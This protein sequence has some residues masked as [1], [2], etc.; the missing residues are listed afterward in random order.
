MLQQSRR[1]RANPGS[2]NVLPE[3][4]KT[5]LRTRPWHDFCVAE[6]SENEPGIMDAPL[7]LF[8]PD[9]GIVT[10]IGDDHW[11][12][13][14]SREAIAREVG[15]LVFTLPASGTAV[16]NADDPLVAPLAAGC[17]ARVIS[18]GI[19]P[20]ADLRAE[21][22]SSN[23]P[24]KLQL[25]LVYNNERAAV[26]SQ[27]CGIHWVS[28]VLGAVAAGLALGLSLKECAAG[29]SGAA[30][31]AGRMEA[32]ALPGGPTFI[33]DD[34]KA[35]FWTVDS[36]LAFMAAAQAS[37]KI[38]VIGTL[39]DCGAGTAEKYVKLAKQALAAADLTIFVGAWASHV[40]KLKNSDNADALR[41]F[42]NVRDAS[43]F[44]KSY[45][46]AGD[47]ILLKGTNKQ[48][49]LY[50]ILLEHQGSV[51]CWRDDCERNDLCSECPQRYTES[52]LPLLLASTQL[53]AP[54]AHGLPTVASGEQVVVGLGNP[55]QEYTN[56]PHNIGYSVVDHMAE[57]LNISW[58][59]TPAA[60]VAT[61]CFNGTRIYLLKVKMAMNLIGAG[62][63]QLALQMSFEPAQCLLVFDDLD[64][65]FGRVKLRMNGGAG[66]H[67]G[68]A[69]ILE[70]FQTA[71][72]RRLKIGI[73]QPDYGNGKVEYVLTPFDDS[74]R[75]T[76]AKSIAVASEK[77]LEEI[78]KRK[79]S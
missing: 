58:N 51:A 22:V 78:T 72:I 33:R 79:G 45:A 48:D 35:P 7:A 64:L 24:K 9:I 36:C 53:A 42:R 46:R 57:T 41:V 55:E 18:Y 25:T 32:V 6:I 73:G 17:A 34:W 70:V 54:A 26:Q 14:N 20:T 76:V 3:V 40:L 75:E 66:G 67:R 68:V 1:G 63:Q 4:A 2:L 5:V 43:D 69:S 16:L 77:A 60:W 30:P 61:G 38:I 8:R 15:K 52:G 21:D 47:L 10:V 19:S 37:R 11:S 13:F 65:N 50:R 28:A 29:I 59:E 31:F 39:S 74:L 12:A 71:D 49:H 27:L 56:T 62:L 44:L 23:W